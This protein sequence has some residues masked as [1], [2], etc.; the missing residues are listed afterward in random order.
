MGRETKHTGTRGTFSG[1]SHFSAF[2]SVFRT[3][4]WLWVISFVFAMK[5]TAAQGSKQKTLRKE[6]PKRKTTAP[7]PRIRRVT[8]R[9]SEVAADAMKRREHVIQQTKIGDTLQELLSRFGLS[10]TE[11]Q[12]WTRSIQ[13]N[14]GPRGLLPAGKE[15]HFYF[16][17]PTPGTRQNPQLKAMEV[18]FSDTS[19]LTWEKGIRGILFQKREKPY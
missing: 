18:D 10:N 16:T 17:K 1:Q 6:A 19:T 15:V 11:R 3:L 4:V 14:I 7:A 8:K 9:Q 12:L 5:P 2:P 13:R